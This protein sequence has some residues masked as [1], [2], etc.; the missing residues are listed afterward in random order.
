MHVLTL[1]EEEVSMMKLGLGF[2]NLG[3]KEILL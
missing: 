3:E 1:G 2:A